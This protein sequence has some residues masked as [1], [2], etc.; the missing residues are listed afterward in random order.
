VRDEGLGDVFG[1]ER[2]L[3]RALYRYPRGCGIPVDVLGVWG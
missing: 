2:A 1:G 3:E